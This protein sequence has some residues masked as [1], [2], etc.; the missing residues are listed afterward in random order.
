MTTIAQTARNNRR[1][2]LAALTQAHD[3]AP[4]TDRRALAAARRKLV[5]DTLPELDFDAILSSCPNKR[6]QH[7]LR[8]STQPAPALV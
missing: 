1:A 8:P 5:A 2:A 6:F 3:L 7:G 4:G